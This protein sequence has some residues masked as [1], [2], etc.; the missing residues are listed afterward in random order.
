MSI[1][2]FSQSCVTLRGLLASH[3][4][5]V[6]GLDGLSVDEQL[7]LTSTCATEVL[8]HSLA[9][10]CGADYEA[11]VKGLHAINM[12][13]RLSEICAEMNALCDEAG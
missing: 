3:T 1:P 6:K 10:I 4:G 5:T 13:Q 12:E 9:I 7:F 8:L 2:E 11:A